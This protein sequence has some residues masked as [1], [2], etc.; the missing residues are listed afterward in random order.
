LRLSDREAEI[1]WYIRFLDGAWK[2]ESVQKQKRLISDLLDLQPREQVLD[3]SC[4]T[5]D[6]VP[7]KAEYVGFE[8]RSVGVDSWSVMIAEAHRQ[9]GD[10]DAVPS[11]VLPR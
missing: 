8:G 6:D 9:A 11:G 10:R 7:A 2:L 3:I 5:G 4:G 1:A